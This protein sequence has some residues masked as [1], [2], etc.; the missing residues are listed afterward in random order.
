MSGLPEL[1]TRVGFASGTDNHFFG[2]SVGRELAG[3][4][5][6]TGLIAMAIV[7]RRI[8]PEERALLDDIGVVVTVA[9]P[10]IWPLKL[11]RLVASYGRTLPAVAAALLCVEGARIGHW[12]GGTGAQRLVELYKRI[13]G[14]VDDRQAIERE[15]E[16]VLSA[17]GRLMGFGVPFREEDERVLALARCLETRQR[18]GLPYWTLFRGVQSVIF[19]RRGLQPNISL[20][21]G[22]ACLDLGFSPRHA[23]LLSAALGQTDYLANAVE[24]A[25]QH[26]TVLQKLP[27]DHV[28]YVGVPA[29]TSPRRRS[30]Q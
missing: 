24:G 20:A 26:P 16:D 17:D 27:V 6:V 10:R 2:W 25:T 4:E 29:R 30:S 7:G 21:V 19:E 13:G 28:H 22:A 14:R 1:P 11:T 8:A 5:T 12:T 9:D 15:A 23:S 3:N 18:T